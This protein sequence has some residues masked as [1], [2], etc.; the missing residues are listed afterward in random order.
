MFAVL[1]SWNY[2]LHLQSFLRSTFR[3]YAL[4][5]LSMADV[6]KLKQVEHVKNEKNILSQVKFDTS[7]NEHI[8]MTSWQ[9]YL[10]KSEKNSSTV[11]K[12]GGY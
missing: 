10:I 4:K 5:I 8:S 1:K 6:I 11:W 12:G 3:Y 9:K 7:V 2:S